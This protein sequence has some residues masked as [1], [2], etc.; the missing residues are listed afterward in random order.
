MHTPPT[1]RHTPHAR[2]NLD[3]PHAYLRTLHFQNHTHTEK[4]CKM[5]QGSKQ[6]WES[7]PKLKRNMPRLRKSRSRSKKSDPRSKKGIQGRKKEVRLKKNDPRSK[8]RLAQSQVRVVSYWY[9]F[10]VN[11]FVCDFCMQNFGTQF[12]P[13]VKILEWENCNYWRYRV[14]QVAST[15]KSRSGTVRLE[16][17]FLYCNDVRC[18]YCTGCTQYLF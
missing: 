9:L 3:I 11:I 8:K 7:R 15:R 10:F 17:H 1:S 14:I 4:K 2:C 5:A 16:I 12:L 13:R 18:L 6:V